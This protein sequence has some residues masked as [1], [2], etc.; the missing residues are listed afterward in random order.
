MINKPL[1]QLIAIPL[2]LLLLGAAC[3]SSV[4]EGSSP[5]PSAIAQDNLSLVTETPTIS[6]TS[7]NTTSAAAPKIQSHQPLPWC[8]SKT[9]TNVFL[10]VRKLNSAPILRFTAFLTVKS[11]PV[12]RLKM[13]YMP[14]ITRNL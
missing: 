9:S 12:A 13:A 1:L 5:F 11:F 6:A 7:S 10:P 8:R 2:A 3:R 4:N 14:L